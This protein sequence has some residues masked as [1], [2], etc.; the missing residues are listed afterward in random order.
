MKRHDCV[1]ITS[2]CEE[3]LAHGRAYVSITNHEPGEKRSDHLHRCQ[4]AW[5]T[6]SLTF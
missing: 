3:S 5:Q 6:A 1:E 4:K 2:E